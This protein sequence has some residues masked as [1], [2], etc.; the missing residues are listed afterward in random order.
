MKYLLLLFTI[1]SAEHSFATETIKQPMIIGEYL[2]H[3]SKLL[4]ESRQINVYLPVSY[5]IKTQQRYPVIYLLDGGLDEDLVHVSG[6]TQ[7]LSFSWVNA[8]PEAIVI[9]IKNIDRRRDFTYPS[10]D[11]TDIKELPTSGKSS[12]FIRY[13]AKELIPLVDT[14]YRTTKSKTLIGQSLGG[15]LASTVLH[16]QPE[17]FSNYLIVSPSLWWDKESLLTK[18]LDL[19][20]FNGRV[21]I[22]VGKEGEI[23]ERVAQQLYDKTMRAG[24]SDKNVSFAFFP[25]LDHGD[26]LHL[27]AYQG[28]GFL[29][30]KKP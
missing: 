2:S 11:I 26:V 3:Q 1:I 6:L 29:F 9:G 27:G 13:L 14:N 8:M 24:L 7:F 23:M 21:F 28:L 17:L 22:T 15:L 4:D 20:S 16:Q 30:K 19:K 12:A 25:E 10:N 18:P 5:S